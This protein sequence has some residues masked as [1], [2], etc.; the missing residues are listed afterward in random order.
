M[1]W[2]ALLAVHEGVEDRL[3]VGEQRFRSV[4]LSETS[5]VQHEDPVA[6]KDR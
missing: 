3:V 1:A 6:V 2:R 4:E 5:R